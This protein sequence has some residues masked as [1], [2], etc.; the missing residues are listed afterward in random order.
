M[1]RLIAA[2]IIFAVVLAVTVTGGCVV[3][4]CH[5]KVQE[6]TATILENPTLQNVINFEDY[7]NTQITLISVFVNRDRVEA[8]GELTAKMHYLAESKEEKEVKEAAEEI[9]YVMETVTR[10]EKLSLQALF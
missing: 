4:R 9:K 8:I 5:K 10:D 6:K 1:K 3:S 2:V 7:W